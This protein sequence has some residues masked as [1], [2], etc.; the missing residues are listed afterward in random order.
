MKKI[1]SA[2][3]F[4]A[5]A[6]DVEEVYRDAAARLGRAL[7]LAG[8]RLVYGG[9]KAGMLGLLSGACLDAKGAI[10]GVIPASFK[11]AGLGNEDVTDMHVVR[12]LHGRKSLMLEKSD[13]FVVLPGGL[14]TLDEAID[15][16]ATKYGRAHDKPVVFINTKGYYAPLL[17]MLDHMIELGFARDSHKTLYQL[18]DTPEEAVTLLTAKRR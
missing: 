2:A 14:G 5:S 10:T 17:S 11:A 16:L 15:V 3:V 4:C 18:V 7:A 8:I 6:A 12:D 13:A 9:E 1:A